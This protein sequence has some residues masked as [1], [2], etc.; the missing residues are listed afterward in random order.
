MYTYTNVYVYVYCITFSSYFY[1]SIKIEYWNSCSVVFIFIESWIMNL[2]RF[3]LFYV[4]AIKYSSKRKFV[5][6]N[7]LYNYKLK[8][9]KNNKI[10][11][12]IS[13]SNPNIP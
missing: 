6:L 10:D 9:Y 12:T 3:I 2:T 4:N 5:Q 1:L 13:N 7:K 8:S 11:N